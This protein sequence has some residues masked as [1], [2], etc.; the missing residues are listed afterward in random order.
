MSRTLTPPP[1]TPLKVAHEQI[2]KRAYDKWVKRGR[3]DGT[4]LQDWLE[5]ERELVA[6]QAR[7][8]SP[9]GRR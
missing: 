8:T 7:P 2:A 5:A 4:H 3:P 6:E 9:A 1:H